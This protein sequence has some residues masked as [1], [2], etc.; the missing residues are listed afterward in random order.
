MGGSYR[1]NTWYTSMKRWRC[2]GKLSGDKLVIKQC[3]RG[4]QPSTS[5]SRADGAAITRWSE[6]P[7]GNRPAPQRDI[8][9]E[10]NN[11][12]L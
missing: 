7:A 6:C 1:M 11:L 3:F 12:E 4:Q 8:N 10:R 9:F 2:S 5:L